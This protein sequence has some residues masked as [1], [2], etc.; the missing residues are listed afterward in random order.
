MLLQLP[1]LM[2]QSES[3][4]AFESLYGGNISKDRLHVFTL[5]GITFYQALPRPTCQ[6]VRY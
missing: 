2:S 1:F 5:P 3:A 4:K 6:M